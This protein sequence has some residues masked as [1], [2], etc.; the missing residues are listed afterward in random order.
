MVVHQGFNVDVLE[1][2]PRLHILAY[3]HFGYFKTS[4][5]PAL[6]LGVKLID[7]FN[8]VYKEN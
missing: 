4:A 8:G 6:T 5:L 3:E 1:K 7:V 2:L